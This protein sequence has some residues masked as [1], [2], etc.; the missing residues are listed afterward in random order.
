MKFAFI[1]KH[2]A[3]WPVAWMCAAL[4]VSRSGF[5]AWLTRQPRASLQSHLSQSMVMP[6]VTIAR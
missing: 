6:R 4:G 1:A 5:H 3:V 2:H